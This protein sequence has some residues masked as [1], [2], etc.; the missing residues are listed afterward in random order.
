MGLLSGLNSRQLLE[1]ITSAFL[2]AWLMVLCVSIALSILRAGQ[3]LYLW[4]NSFHAS[5]SDLFS[6]FFQGGRFDLKVSATAGLVMLPLFVIFPKRAGWIAGTAI[7][8][9]I[10]ISLINLHYFGFYKTPIDPIV[11]GIFEDDT[12]AILQTIWKDFPVILTLTSLVVISAAA[13]IT[14]KWLYVRINPLVNKASRPTWVLVVGI[15]LA[16]VLMVFSIK[17]TLRSIGLLRQNL[18]VTTSQFLNDMVPNGAIALLFAWELRKDAQN[19][20]D[21]LTGLKNMGFNSPFDAAKELGIKTQ[22]PET[23][24]QALYVNGN[25]IAPTKHKKN[26]LFFMMESWSAEP[27]LYQSPAFDVLGRLESNL[28]Q[29]CHF[30]NFDS[31]QG[32]THSSLEAILFS[33]PITPL[34]TGIEGRKPIPWGIPQI[35]KKAGYDTVFITSGRAGW[36]DLDRVMRTQGFDEIVDALTLIQM[37]PDAKQGIW[38]VWDSYAFWYLS[39]RLKKQ[40]GRP[41]FVFVL[42]MTNHPPY[43]LPPEYPRVKRDMSK[44]L[45]EHN[46]ENLIASLD[47]YQ[48][49]SD[50]LGGLVQ[51]V[52]ESPKYSDTLIAATGDHNVRTF[53]MYAT[54]ERR[55]LI[56]QVPFIVWGEG[57]TCG[58]QLKKPASHRDMFPTLFPLMG[59]ESGYLNTGRNLFAESDNAANDPLNAPRSLFY[60]GHARSTQG[61]WELDNPNSFVCTP[62]KAE[63]DSCK[64]NAKDDREERARLGLQDWF[65]RSSLHP[66]LNKT[67]LLRQSPH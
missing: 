13:I 53:G 35:L 20:S 19:L 4:P 17:G 7:T 38:G 41:L 11:F 3:I 40:S 47:T 22:D 50:L 65:I 8:V 5:W 14:K 2:F 18:T 24:R 43:N 12:K 10:F 32:G 63:G 39:D 16:F 26:L 61:A 1:K 6:V 54:P 25:G 46:S 21:L 49:S 56:N 55:Y 28:L 58:S 48:Y 37:Y 27:F 36:R 23:L 67:E 9:L 51:E 57:L 64:F 60:D 29:G 52:R 30:T 66:D 33:T 15:M 31:A 42:T 34:T 62:V 44:W 59:L 45:G